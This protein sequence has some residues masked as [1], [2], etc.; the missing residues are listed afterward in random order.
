[1]KEISWE[2]IYRQAGLLAGR[3]EGKPLTGIYGIPTGGVPIA[4]I[5]AGILGLP[6]LK[7]PEPGC[8]IVDDLIDS[9]KTMARFDGHHRDALFRKPHSPNG[10]CM[11]ATRENE[12]LAF[13]WEKD[14]GHPTD[15][16]IRL[17]EF[18]GE[19]PSREGLLDTPKRVIKALN[20]MTEGYKQDPGIILSTVFE[21][22]GLQYDQMIVL[23]GIEFSSLCEHHLQPFRGTAAV[24][25][26]PDGKIVGLSKL[27]RLVDCFARRLQVQERMTEQI[28]AAL[29]DHLN[30]L[31]AAVYIEAHHA[32][33]GNRGVRKHQGIMT[34]QALHG[35]MR[36]DG[37]ARAEFMRLAMR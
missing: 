13:P 18:I 33:M 35:A 1:M 29:I 36:D 20:E 28:K 3:W 8:L 5:I 22:P 34:T 14:D 31:G 30:P 21:E 7:E 4:I 6:M 37:D 12:W 17:L 16:V 25:Y 19:D 15:A 24:G 32:C 26:I 9:G 2:E 27:A 11:E 23:H 10:I